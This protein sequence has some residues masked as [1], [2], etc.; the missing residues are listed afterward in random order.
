MGFEKS[1]KMSDHVFTWEV[2][3]SGGVYFA[4]SAPLFNRTFEFKEIPGLEFDSKL[5]INKNYEEGPLFEIR[6]RDSTLAVCVDSLKKLKNYLHIK[7][8]YSR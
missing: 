2:N 4:N 1:E 6:L 5:R 3:T 7:V 8:E